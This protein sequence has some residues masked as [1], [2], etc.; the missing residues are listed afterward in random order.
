MVQLK[1]ANE[2][3]IV[4]SDVT[5]VKELLEDRTNETSNR[6]FFHSIHA[7][8]GGDYFGFAPSGECPRLP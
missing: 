4:L 7:V 5:I 8:T 1:V 3:I 2:T 6:P